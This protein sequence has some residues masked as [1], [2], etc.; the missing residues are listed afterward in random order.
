M[1]LVGLVNMCDCVHVHVCC[2][3]YNIMVFL[4]IYKLAGLTLSLITSWVWWSSSHVYVCVC[5]AIPMTKPDRVNHACH[6]AA[7]TQLW[8]HCVKVIDRHT[9]MQ[10][11]SATRLTCVIR[12]RWNELPNPEN[13]LWPNMNR[14][15]TMVKISSFIDRRI[16]PHRAYRLGWY[17]KVYLP[18]LLWNIII[19][20]ESIHYRPV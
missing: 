10:L 12:W 8:L 6:C 14:K 20:Y 3:Y 1:N 15:Q 2:Q 5:P 13:Q 4:R 18:M 16:L 17:S 19:W 11:T 9:V 7:K